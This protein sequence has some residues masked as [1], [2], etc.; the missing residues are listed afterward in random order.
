MVRHAPSRETLLM[1]EC[2]H[3]LFVCGA[4]RSGTTA[5]THLLAAH[6]RIVLGMERYAGLVGPDAFRLTP[7]HFAKQRFLKVAPGDT[8]Y[9]DFHSVHWF[10]TEIPAKIDQCAYIGDKKPEL[11]LVYDALFRAFPSAIVL[12]IF[13]DP[14]AVA[15]SYQ[16]RR[17]KGVQWPTWRDYRAA[18]EDWNNAMHATLDAMNRGHAVHALRYEDLFQSTDLPR[19]VFDTLELDMPDCVHRR[20]DGLRRRSGELEQAR[21]CVL[22]AG[23]IDE[24]RHGVDHAAYDV[25][26]EVNLLS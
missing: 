15:S 4:A 7:E 3:F 24:V 8:F 11:Y 18:I 26:R 2:R 16:A 25:I 19:A 1:P 20:I 5:L 14:V 23:Q 9:S 22:S 21:Q 13:R 10:D 6:P 12:M 17:D